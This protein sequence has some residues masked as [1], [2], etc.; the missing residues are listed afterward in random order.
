MWIELQSVQDGQV[1]ATS[2]GAARRFCLTRPQ[3]G[4]AHARHDAQT[5]QKLFTKPL[6][7]LPMASPRG[8]GGPKCGGGVLGD[9][10]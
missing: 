3:L 7:Q 9:R 8:Q 6:A 2:G 4:A 1:H 10:V 5:T